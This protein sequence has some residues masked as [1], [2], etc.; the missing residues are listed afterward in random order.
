MWER[1]WQLDKINWQEVSNTGTITYSY[2]WYTVAGW[3]WYG[4]TCL[5]C[6]NEPEHIFTT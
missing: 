1:H 6:I 3:T 4:V 5:S 2:T